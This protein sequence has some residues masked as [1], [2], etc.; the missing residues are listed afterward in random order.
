MTGEGVRHLRALGHTPRAAGSAEEARARDYV[1]AA[2]HP[3]G[4]ETREESFSY[5]PLPGR[6]GTPAAGALLTGTLVLGSALALGAHPRGAAAVL[7]AGVAAV[8]GLAGAL[9]GAGVLRAGGGGARGVNLVATRGRGTPRVWLCAHLDTKS[10]PLPSA[11]RIGGVLLLAAGTGLALVL[12]TLGPGLAPRVGW[13]IV[14]G[15]A[16]AGG[17]P[18][19]ASR[20]GNESPGAVDNA[21]GVAA[22]LAAA[23]RLPLDACVGVL[24]TSAE[25]LGMAGARAWARG[26]AG[27]I[28]LNCDG[29]DDVGETTLMHGRV[30]PQRLIAALRATTPALR[31]RRMPLG[32]L[33]DSTALSGAGLESGTLCHGT[34]ATLAR[35]HRPSD[36]LANLRGLRIDEVSALL[37]AAATR[38]AAEIAGAEGAP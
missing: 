24:I 29:V 16:L 15:C 5:S 1:A 27:E 34:M 20:V 17:V 32:L 33:T 4:F 9:L 14:L 35:V 7:L 25:E 38:L 2:L 37:A 22:V 3:L 19:A 26:R 23:A 36:S 18:V 13:W 30:R 12:A 8:A 10:Q 11:V 6:F 31:V 28:V 21:S